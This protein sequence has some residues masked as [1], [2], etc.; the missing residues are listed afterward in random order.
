MSMSE[1]ESGSEQSS[2]N[3]SLHETMT[4]KSENGGYSYTADYTETR[5]ETTM[6]NTET[7]M[8]GIGSRMRESQ[9]PKVKTCDLFFSVTTS[10]EKMRKESPLGH[11]IRIEGDV[12]EMFGKKDEIENTNGALLVPIGDKSQNGSVTHKS[13]GSGPKNVGSRTQ[14][15]VVGIESFMYN[16]QFPIAFK[17]DVEGLA[18]AQPTTFSHKGERTADIVSA[19]RGAD[20]IKQLVDIKEVPS[21]NPNFEG[22]TPDT[23]ENAISKHTYK[24]ETV[25][26]KGDKVKEKITEMYA[27]ADH[28]VALCCNEWRRDRKEKPYPVDKEKGVKLDPE[29][30]SVIIGLIKSS[31]GA[32]VQTDLR[33]LQIKITP[34]GSAIPE[35]KIETNIQSTSQSQSQPTNRIVPKN[36]GAPTSQKIEQKAPAPALTLSSSVKNMWDIGAKLFSGLSPSTAK[37]P[38]TKATLENTEYTFEYGIRVRYIN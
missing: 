8:N 10:I 3:E 30:A 26:E 12:E 24:K 34:L 31:L 22:Y 2:Y 4:G 9:A 23:I 32:S 18:S 21:T 13:S 1:S 29:K 15:K 37:S 27:P 20:R 28:P 19:N 6:M 5:N 36:F 17:V 14:H 35:K 38:A 25:D 33:D 7:N 16:N 11:I